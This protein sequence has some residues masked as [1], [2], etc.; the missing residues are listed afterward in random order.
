MG[1]RVYL[2]QQNVDALRTVV[3]D[4]VYHEIERIEHPTQ[5]FVPVSEVDEAFGK[6]GGEVQGDLGQVAYVDLCQIRKHRGV[7]LI[8]AGEESP[9]TVFFMYEEHLPKTTEV[10]DTR[11][12]GRLI[13]A[14]KGSWAVVAEPGQPVDPI[15][16]RLESSV[17]WD[18]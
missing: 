4:H 5:D 3:L 14:T 12:S 1:L 8:L 13:P 6:F 10:A 17:R 18:L 7:H 11:F 16:D 2:T 15:I 9:V